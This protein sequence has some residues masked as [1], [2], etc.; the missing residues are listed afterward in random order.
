[1]LRRLASTD[2]L[3][4]LANRR[5]MGECLLQQERRSIENLAS[6]GLILADID[7]FKHINDNYGHDCGD[8]V[9]T[10]V[11][12]ALQAALRDR[13]V[14]ARWGGEEFLLVLPDTD[15]EGTMRVAMK[16]R[17]AI[18]CLAIYYEHQLIQPTLSYGVVSGDHSNK[19]EDCIKRAD[20]CLYQAK[21]KGRNCIIQG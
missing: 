19:A 8:K 1:M 15:I 10:E 7:H 11:A 18:A 16:M 14:V 4:G 9:I 21:H 20:N 12:S 2:E 17:N 3:T 5:T 13:D 6:Y